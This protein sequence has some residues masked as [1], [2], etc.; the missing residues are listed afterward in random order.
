MNF[1]EK[2][3]LIYQNDKVKITVRKVSKHAPLNRVLDEVG[4]YLIDFLK[5]KDITYVITY[6]SLKSASNITKL[7]VTKFVKT[8]EGS[9]MTS[10]DETDKNNINAIINHFMNISKKNVLITI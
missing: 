3:L 2:W 7:L 8:D 4:Y 10:L 5:I 1:I 9:T 6:D